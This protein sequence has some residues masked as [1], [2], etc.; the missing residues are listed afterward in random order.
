M[1]SSQQVNVVR[2]DVVLIRCGY[3]RQLHPVYPSYSCQLH[4]KTSSI[5]RQRQSTFIV[6][7]V[8]KYEGVVLVPPNLVGNTQRHL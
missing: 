4:L 2:S 8:T 1:S 3:K 7:R 5:I 6:R